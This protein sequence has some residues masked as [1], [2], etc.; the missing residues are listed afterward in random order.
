[1]S[2]TQDFVPPLILDAASRPLLLR[3]RDI[4][5]TSLLWAGWLYLLL[6]AIG[7]VWVPPFVQHMLPVEPPDHPW[8]VLRAALLCVSIAVFVCALMLIRVLFERRKFRGEDRRRYFPRPDDAVIG[9]AFGVPPADLPGWRAARRLVVHHD[10][11]GRV[12]GV[13]AG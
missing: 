3:L 2:A 6:A 13:D 8:L 10:E 7:A 12:T 11:E 9:A 4:I 5:L 1:M